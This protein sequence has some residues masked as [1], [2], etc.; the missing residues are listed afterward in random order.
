MN[1]ML[2]GPW[3]YFDLIYRVLV[4]VLGK[5]RVDILIPH[6]NNNTEGRIIHYSKS[7]EYVNECPRDCMNINERYI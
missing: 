6:Y 4:T 2:V 3:R 5:A 1:C 7:F